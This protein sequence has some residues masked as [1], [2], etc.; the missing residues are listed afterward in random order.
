[1]H[2]IAVVAEMHC[3]T[4]KRTLKKGNKSRKTNNYNFI[5]FQTREINPTHVHV[6]I[7]NNSGTGNRSFFVAAFE[8]LHN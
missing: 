8:M 3:K 4:Y 6:V 2:L 7:S 5:V 1:M